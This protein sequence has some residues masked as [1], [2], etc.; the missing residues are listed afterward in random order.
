MLYLVRHSEAGNKR[1]WAGPDSQRP[2]TEAGWR[3]AH[4]LRTHL[5]G[6]PL[7]AIVSS[8]ALRCVQTV[9]PL[10]RRLDLEIQTDSRLHVDG[11]A[12]QAI[13]LLLD[14]SD[15]HVLWCTHG[16]LIGDVLTRLR[17]G[18][19]PIHAAPQWVKGSVWR[20]EV[21]DGAVVSAVYQP[22]EG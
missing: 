4:W 2:L 17:D 9:Q 16:E 3:Q 18:G 1:V 20:L 19:A 5:G 15:T 21:F 22:P 10:A 8:P 14:A 7:T 13:R 6:C 12:D 11:D